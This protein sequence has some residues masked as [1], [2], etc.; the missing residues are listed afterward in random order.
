MDDKGRQGGN[1]HEE[2]TLYIKKS[3]NRIAC[4]DA[5]ASVLDENRNLLHEAFILP[6][7]REQGF[8]TKIMDKE[9]MLDFAV[10][11]GL[12]VPYSVTVESTSGGGVYPIRVL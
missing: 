7:V 6:G 1:S 9:I 2:C 4:Y 10:K 12:N 8:L 11:A 3:C 5:V